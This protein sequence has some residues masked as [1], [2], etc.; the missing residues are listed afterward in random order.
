MSDKIG[1]AAGTMTETERDAIGDIERRLNA[2]AVVAGG[3][4]SVAAVEPL[5]GNSGVNYVFTLVRDGIAEEPLV[6]RLSPA[7]VRRRG[8]TDVL[9]QVPLLDAL[10]RAGLPVAL[11]RWSEAESGFFG[12]DA[13]IQ[14]FIDGRPLHMFDPNLS[15]AGGPKEIECMVR[16]GIDA[17]VAIHAFDWRT[18]LSRW[19]PPRDITE[20][21][22]F[23]ER[24]S[25]RMAEPDWVGEAQALAGQLRA[26]APSSAP[27]GLVHGDFQMNNVLFSP[28][29]E[30]LAVIDWEIAGI[31]PQPLDL[32]WL[33]LMTDPTCWHDDYLRDLRVRCE[34]GALLEMYERAGG[35]P[36]ER[37]E[38]W[39][40]LAC[41][42]F[43]VIAGF[44]L[45]LH[46]TGKR[47][48]ELYET[49]ATSVP[50]MLARGR[51]L[52]DAAP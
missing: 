40:A 10:A 20:E 50:V 5:S 41:F 31:G 44:N 16:Q 7:D 45:R 29:H 27:L 30:L 1:G 15:V 46:R 8:N 19:S 21:L 3:G 52:I 6:L 4:G 33:A 49:L 35:A 14:E 32:G 23:W 36:I 9:R 12:T 2:W 22:G 51:E 28:R 11:I 38:W 17:M 47:T 13:F 48:D 37:F 43:A 18:T 39:E 34:P 42:R 24:L 25:D 26:T